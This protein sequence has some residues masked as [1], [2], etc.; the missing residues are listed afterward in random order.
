MAAP[1][2]STPLLPAQS[3]SLPRPTIP[4]SPLS[5]MTYSYLA[6]LFK[7]QLHAPQLD[8]NDLFELP[9]DLT[10]EY[11]ARRMYHA[12]DAE[13]RE[14]GPGN[15]SLVS[16][17]LK[18]GVANSF[19]VAA[20]LRI[21][22]DIATFATPVVFEKLIRFFSA[23]PRPSLWY[24][25]SL[26]VLMF[27][28][29]VLAEVILHPQYMHLCGDSGVRAEASLAMLLQRK[30]LRLDVSGRDRSGQIVSLLTVDCKSAGP[31]LWHY[32]HLVWS[33][34]IKV[35]AGFG[36]LYELIGP[37][38]IAG[39][40]VM[41][42]AVCLQSLQVQFMY[43]MEEQM[44]A[45]ADKR[46]RLIGEVLNIIRQI[47]VTGLEWMFQKRIGNLREREMEVCWR[48]HVYDALCWSVWDSLSTIFVCACFGAAALWY[49]ETLVPE[50]VFSVLAVIEGKSVQLRF[51]NTPFHSGRSN[52]GENDTTARQF[53]KH[54]V[55]VLTRSTLY[56]SRMAVIR[57][58]LIYLPESFQGLM[59]AR[60]S[61]DRIRAFLLLP[62]AVGR[63]QDSNLNERELRAG[64]LQGGVLSWG[65]NQVIEG[66]R[67]DFPPRKL[68]LLLGAVASGKSSILAGLLGEMQW[69]PR[70]QEGCNEHRPTL[71]GRIVSYCPQEP[72]LF[73][74][75]VPHRSNC[76]LIVDRMQSGGH[77]N[78]MNSLFVGREGVCV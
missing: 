57:F 58:P 74:V 53:Q 33:G 19:L 42:L 7:R 43:R 17:L 77:S 73:D 63:L 11:N 67:F 35:I 59:Q 37:P 29:F 32:L 41:V 55:H 51:S 48:A 22:F 39:M 6:P 45:W 75:C 72:F 71:N 3:D 4:K 14:R 52:Y 20:P 24:A 13:L 54:S 62:E 16:A 68:T 56:C 64:A 28:L 5:R 21:F 18:S 47:K 76:A 78:F 50:K 61:L 69:D 40:A 60:V 8:A 15:A 46:L 25:C 23:A 34:P 9:E 26:V 44:L 2:E 27:L 12:W 36:L 65:N 66:Q 1:A 70:D 38:A 49:P 31:E 30:S 10:A